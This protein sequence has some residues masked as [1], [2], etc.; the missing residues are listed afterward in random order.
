MRSSMWCN[1]RCH[2]DREPGQ[3][4]WIAYYKCEDGH[5][6]GLC[7]VDDIPVVEDPPCFSYVERVCYCGAE[8]GRNDGPHYVRVLSRRRVD[9]SADCRKREPL[10]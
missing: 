9:V 6:L 1:T 2:G 7:E 5:L 10:V 3:W 8:V 4:G